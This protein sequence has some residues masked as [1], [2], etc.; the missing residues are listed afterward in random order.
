MYVYEEN[1]EVIP[2]CDKT[3]YVNSVNND[4]STEEVVYDELCKLS[5]HKPPGFDVIYPVM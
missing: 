4:D 3:F 2:M 1:L 5:V